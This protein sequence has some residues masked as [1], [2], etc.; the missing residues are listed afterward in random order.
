MKCNAFLLVVLLGIF[1]CALRPVAAAQDSNTAAKPSPP[2]PV[3]YRL[4]FSI[5]ELE[6]GK[7][8]NSRHYSMNLM[9]ERRELK[10]GVRV[11]IEDGGKIDYLDVGTYITA[12]LETSESP[13]ILDVSAEFSSLPASGQGTN[14]QAPLVRLARIAATAVVALNKP[15]VVGSVDDPD[16][17]REFELEVTAAKLN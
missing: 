8:L 13:L 16:S 10:V 17:K 6:N 9:G 3:A 2:K 15:T 7:K 4:D 12:H 1:A 5:N 14:L 11:P